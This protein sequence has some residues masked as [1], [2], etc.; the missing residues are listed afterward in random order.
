MDNLFRIQ[1]TDKEKK[2]NRERSSGV[3]PRSR[4]TFSIANKTIPRAIISPIGNQTTLVEGKKSDPSKYENL[5]K[6][7]EL[8]ET[9]LTSFNEGIISLIV[10]GGE[11]HSNSFRADKF[12]SINLHNE[13]SSLTT[14]PNNKMEISTSQPSQYRPSMVTRQNSSDI[15]LSHYNISSSY[16]P[17]VGLRR[18]ENTKPTDLGSIRERSEYDYSYS[19]FIKTRK[20]EAPLGGEQGESIV[21][22]RQDL[23][24]SILGKRIYLHQYFRIKD[25]IIYLESSINKVFDPSDNLD[26]L[27]FQS[28]VLIANENDEHEFADITMEG[29]VMKEE[30]LWEFLR[31]IELK[32]F[33]SYPFDSLDFNHCEFLLKNVIAKYMSIEID[34]EKKMISP[35]PKSNP[36]LL[37]ESIDL[38]IFDTSYKVL[39]YYNEDNSFFLA[40]QATTTNEYRI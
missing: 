29:I 6:R 5:V 40:F 25:I 26:H 33:D 17:R 20:F 19:S 10:D 32:F 3:I 16:S 28:E 35:L 14:A 38:D 15:S 8:L 23:S 24:E 18:V 27:V 9:N 37:I 34:I 31:S 12:R 7:L 4:S 36:D 30:E 39:F 21:I 13:E 1:E 22:N 11:K 2:L